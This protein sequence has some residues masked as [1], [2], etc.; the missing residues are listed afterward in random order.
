MDQNNPYH[1]LNLFDHT[2]LA[3][4]IIE[5]E[6]HLRLTMLLHDIG[7]IKTRVN[8]ADGISHFYNHAEESARMANHF[9]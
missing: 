4:A 2:V 9:N 8:D 7:K 1:H 6:L 3:T 5:P